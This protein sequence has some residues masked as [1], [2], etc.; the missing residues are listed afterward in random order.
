MGRSGR[1]LV[2]CDRCLRRINVTAKRKTKAVLVEDAAEVSAS[3]PLAVVGKCGL[4]IWTEEPHG[5]DIALVIRNVTVELRSHG[6]FV[7]PETGY[8][9][10]PD[11]RDNTACG[12]GLHGLLDGIGDWSLLSDAPDARWQIV[13]VAR[14]EIVRI[15]DAKVKFPR[16]WVTF[17]GSAATAKKTIIPAMVASVFKA[18][19]GNTAT[20]DS[21]H[22][23]ATGHSGHAA[24]TGDSGHAAATGHRGHAAATGDSGHAAATGHRGHAAATGYS[25]H[26]AATGDSGHAAATGDRGIAASLGIAARAKA[27]KGGAIMLAEWRETKDF[28]WEVAHVFA[29]K[30]GENGIEPDTWYEL[31]DGAPVKATV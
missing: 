25:G 31:K 4:P 6:G 8:V 16:G 2:A 19:E 26:A 11:W 28:K 5:D 29:S 20:G 24:A 23:A 17:T 15:D 18:A 21:G 13:K 14:A 7:W 30:V 1:A 10:A 9:E 22:A 27:T 12:N 3:P